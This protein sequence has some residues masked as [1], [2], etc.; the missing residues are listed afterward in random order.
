MSDA[1]H[2]PVEADVGPR[3][4]PG[5]GSMPPESDAG[6]TFGWKTN[7]VMFVLTVVSV[8]WAGALYVGASPLAEGT[9]GGALRGLSRGASFGLPLLA[10]L[11]FHEFGHYFAARVH[12]VPASLP[13]FIPFPNPFGTMGAIISMPARIRSRDALLDIG[14]AGPLAGLVVALP[15][16][17]I[18]LARSAVT[19]LA[20]EGV[21]LE[22]QSL[23]YLLLKRIA[24]GEI[25]AGHDVNLSPTAF[26]GWT[27]LLLTALNL[28][29]IGQ[30]DGGHVAYALFGERQH[31]YA[32][33]F[34]HGLLV[35][36]AYNLAT[37]VGPI[38]LGRGGSL[39]QAVGNST[40]WLVWYVLLHVIGRFSG[41][42]HPPTEPGELSPKRRAIAWLTL[43]LFL[44]LFMPTPWQEL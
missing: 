1:E 6:H 31:R 10:I 11:L 15:V 3:A 22:G 29:P 4:S 40:F 5:R 21:I 19:P 36:F 44:G 2:A 43:A 30:L 37:F 12:R 9:L 35:A 8:H 26:A 24:V 33:M 25:P 20:S 27:G 18:G 34:H 42:D 28:I 39:G 7:A 13:Y 16:T 17:L 41:R 38:A 14:A 23:I 32:R